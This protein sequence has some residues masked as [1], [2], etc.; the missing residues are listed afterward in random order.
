MTTQL[1]PQIAAEELAS[2]VDAFV[3]KDYFSATEAK[4][5]FVEAKK[6]GLGLRLHADEF[7]DCE[8]A[9]LAASLGAASA[10]HL[11]YASHDGLRKM[12]EANVVA[13]LLPGTSLYTGIPFANGRKMADLGCAVAIATD[14]NPG[15]SPFVN[16]PFLA[17]MAGVH[18]KLKPAEIIAGITFVASKA[19]GLQSEVG[20][21]EPGYWADIGIYSGKTVEEW[22]ADMGRTK[23]KLI[24]IAGKPLSR[25]SFIT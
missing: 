11:Q 22:L 12:A 10:D 7:S 17:A 16:L 9:A 6:L 14:F 23:P 2:F 5:W 25:A 21:L 13:T 24:F 15:S 8:G 3:E 1:L 18:G 4:N 20:A 19:L